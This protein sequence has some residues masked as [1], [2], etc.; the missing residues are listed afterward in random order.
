M[1]REN[2]TRAERIDNQLAKAGW[3]VSSRLIIEE[4]WLPKKQIPIFIERLNRDVFL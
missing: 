1:N 4:L 2:M 3:S